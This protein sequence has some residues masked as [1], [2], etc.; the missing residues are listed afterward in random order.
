MAKR[1]RRGKN[2]TRQPP[3]SGRVAPVGLRIVGG[4]FR[5]RKLSYGGD[6]RVRPMKDR[7]REAVFNLLGPAIRGTRVYDLFA[8]TGAM[9][10]EAISRGA[11]SAV[12]IEHH[13]P[14][15]RLIRENIATLGAG[16]VCEVITAD[17]FRRFNEPPA[18][19][20]RPWLVFCCPPYDFFIDRRDAAL[21]LIRTFLQAAPARSAIVVESDDRFDHSDLPCPGDWDTRRYPPAVVGIYWKPDPIPPTE[22]VS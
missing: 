21:S 8:G 15:A 18:A 2:Q 7:T 10:L 20:E 12:L 3:R 19:G 11:A 9:A 1:S 16:E 17:V 5:G 22:P 4:R 14:T 6:L 13:V